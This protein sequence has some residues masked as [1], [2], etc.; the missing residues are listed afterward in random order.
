MFKRIING[1]KHTGQGSPV[2]TD[3]LREAMLSFFP[4]SGEINKYLTFEADDK[5]HDGFAAVWKY[6][7]W[8]TDSDNNRKRYLLKFT[9][10][11]D[12]RSDEKAVYFKTKRFA[13]TKRPPRGTEVL[14]PWFIGIGIGD[15]ET[16]R[17]EYAKVFKVFRP[18]KKLQMLVEKATSMGW[19]AYL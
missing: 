17:E 15:P 19:D 14:Q 6:F 7:M 13:R 16:I 9:V 1:K 11:V 3:A 18:K 8:D 5:A 2:P 10:R 4:K 12:I